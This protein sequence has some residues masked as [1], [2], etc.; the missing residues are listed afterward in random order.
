MKI[1]F[2]ILLSI[3][4]YSCQLEDQ[5]NSEIYTNVINNLG[6]WQTPQKDESIGMELNFYGDDIYLL[7]G[8]SSVIAGGIDSAELTKFNHC[9]ENEF[10]REIDLSVYDS[11]SSQNIISTMDEFGNIYVGNSVGATSY[12][13][14][15]GVKLSKYDL[16]GNL[17]WDKTVPVG[18]IVGLDSNL[19]EIK[20]FNNHLYLVGKSHGSLGNN[21]D[22]LSWYQDDVLIWKYSASDGALIWTHQIGG[23]SNVSYESDYGNDISIDTSGN[24]YV[25]GATHGILGSV[26]NNTNSSG[27]YSGFLMKLDESGNRS[28]VS[29]ISTLD[30][31]STT[32]LG[33]EVIGNEVFVV[34]DSGGDID[35]NTTSI[36]G[37]VFIAKYDDSGNQLWIKF[38]EDESLSYKAEFEKISTNEFVFAHSGYISSKNAISISKL[39]SDGD[40]ITEKII[41][42]GREDY[43]Y[44]LEIDIS[45][46][47]FLTGTTTGSFDSTINYFQTNR[48]FILKLDENL[49]LQ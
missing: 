21:N 30:D 16:T 29:H 12:P 43:L 26:T 13:T 2:I 34:G 47:I 23:G 38:F 24:L 35:N 15:V 48:R 31:N 17:I 20:Y 11:T 45:N 44:D 33:V 37:G 27:K 6:C 19:A 40:I 22:N 5:D 28:W 8:N 3:I 14:A 46:N 41:N 7:E 1:F 42:S 18:N 32:A 4:L 25:V 10:S 49:N 36:Q 9:G 39:D